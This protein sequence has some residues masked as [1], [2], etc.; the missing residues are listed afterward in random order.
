MSSTYPSS[1][2]SATTDNSSHRRRSVE[3]TET[4]YTSTTEFLA[5]VATEPP[6]NEDFEHY[7]NID[8]TSP[9]HSNHFLDQCDQLPSV[10][11]LNEAANI[12][13]LDV[14]NNE[15]AFKHLYNNHQHHGQ[16]HLILFIRHWYCR[17]SYRTVLTC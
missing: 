14:D 2:P 5:A 1:V 4:D 16:R 8:A 6:R 7:P 9:N 10:K 11:S 3:S 17:V 13:V 12:P 15:L